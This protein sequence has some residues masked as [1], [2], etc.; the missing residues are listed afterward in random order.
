MAVFAALMPT[1]LLGLVP[2]AHAAAGAKLVV[3]DTNAVGIMAT[4][5]CQWTKRS[6]S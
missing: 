2:D 5:C 6:G 4:G 1:W 3:N